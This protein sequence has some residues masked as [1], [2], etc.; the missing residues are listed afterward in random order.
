MA[1]GQS[2][3]VPSDF[4]ICSNLAQARRQSL[5]RGVSAQ[6]LR[7]RGVYEVCNISNDLTLD[8]MEA[9]E[10]PRTTD[11]AGR[12][13]AFVQQ[14]FKKSRCLK[15]LFEAP[16]TSRRREIA[17]IGFVVDDEDMPT[18]IFEA[19]SKNRETIGFAKERRGKNHTVR[20]RLPKSGCRIGDRDCAARGVHQPGRQAIKISQVPD[21]SA[22]IFGEGGGGVEV[23]QIITD[24][25]SRIVSDDRQS[26]LQKH[27]A[28]AD[29]E[30][31]GQLLDESLSEIRGAPRPPANK[32]TTATG[33]VA[34]SS[35]TP[36]RIPRL[37]TS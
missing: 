6:F 2:L 37:A 5:S 35:K 4:A 8:A 36:T 11:I 10:M 25:R 14:N 16:D 33:S 1:S 32:T 22:D 23:P 34:A 3:D 27:M 20:T 13:P 12:P 15:F 30:V 21:D 19:G 9:M 29:R 26:L 17:F 7:R 18:N 31:T 28:A 24:I